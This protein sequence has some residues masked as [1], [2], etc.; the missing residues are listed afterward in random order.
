MDSY[1]NQLLSSFQ[2]FETE[3]CLQ[4]ASDWPSEWNDI[5]IPIP[6]DYSENPISL[7]D[8]AISL[9]DSPNFQNNP[10]S[11]TAAEECNTNQS[12]AGT[13][14]PDLIPECTSQFTQEICD[15]LPHCQSQFSEPQTIITSCGDFTTEEEC[16]EP[17]IKNYVL[18]TGVTIY[19]GSEYLKQ[20]ELGDHL[21]DV[22]L[23][24][25]RYFKDGSFQMY[26]FL[27]MD[28]DGGTPTDPRYWKNIIPENYTIYEREG[29]GGINDF[30]LL[31]DIFTILSI[32]LNDNIIDYDFFEQKLQEY[33]ICTGAC[34]DY[35]VAAYQSL[36]DNNAEINLS[37]QEKLIRFDINNDD[38]ISVQDIIILVEE[39][40]ATPI[41]EPYTIDPNSTQ[42]WTGGYYYPVLPKLKA[43]GEFMDVS[44]DITR[45]QN[46]G[47]NVPFGS[48]RNWNDDDE[49]AP[50]TNLQ[51]IDE[52]SSKMLID[53]DFSE[54]D[55]DSLGD[56][57]GNNNLG[58]LIG[59][60]RIEFDG[61][62][63]SPNKTS[64]VNEPKLE[65][66]RGKAF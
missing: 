54:I 52:F 47:V 12:C 13:I 40:I 33:G 18:E 60:Y 15:I 25:V 50:I 62:T 61:E 5:I 39:Y 42:Q 34:P 41:L 2:Y 26:E 59:D 36:G 35:I 55:E 1:G 29:V 4:Y 57:S 51:I 53:L 17:C 7:Y 65:F 16:I 32:T 27:G 31:L 9:D 37:E 22:D 14:N 30:Q 64:N 3:L 58:I 63:L 48:E 21:G 20:G 38:D 10:E 19:D 11:C 45:L 23:A 46:N 44:N 49:L 43:N 28:E 8:I 66:N 56:N 24:Q 6:N